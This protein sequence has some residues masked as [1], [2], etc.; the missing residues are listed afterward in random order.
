[1]I[2]FTCKSIIFFFISLFFTSNLFAQD[3]NTET[4]SKD[5][6]KLIKLEQ[7]VTSA[8]A[9]IDKTNAKLDYADSLMQVGIGSTGWTTTESALCIS[10]TDYQ[11]QTPSDN[12]AAVFR[13]F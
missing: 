9:K 5:E 4:L 3:P 8:Q 1:M 12:C 13:N 10:G 11:L 2:K 6:L 7:K